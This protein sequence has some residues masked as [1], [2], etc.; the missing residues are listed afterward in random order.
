MSLGRISHK[1][2]VDKKPLIRST[3]DN[4][5]IVWVEIQNDQQTRSNL[6]FSGFSLQLLR[7]S[8]KDIDQMVVD[9]I[10]EHRGGA[11]V[12]WE[13]VHFPGDTVGGV[14][15][16]FQDKFLQKHATQHLV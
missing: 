14:C 13:G 1:D 12:V 10:V 11:V 5:K 6:D 8:P 2:A 7:L 4:N 15:S 9:P 3:K 16:E